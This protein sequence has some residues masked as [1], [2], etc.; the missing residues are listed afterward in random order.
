MSPQKNKVGTANVTTR[1]RHLEDVRG[2]IRRNMF[3]GRRLPM[4]VD[5]VEKD[6][7]GGRERNFLEPLMRFVRDDVRDLVASPKNDHGLSCQRYGASQ[8]CSCPKISICE[9]FGAVRFSTFSTVSVKGRHF[10][11]NFGCLLLL[12]QRT[13]ANP[14]RTSSTAA[15]R[16]RA[17]VHVIEG[18]Y[19]GMVGICPSWDATRSKAH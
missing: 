16:R 8:R 15:A 9:I 4:W 11:G 10:A 2:A 12:Q 17:S 5:T 7:L 6:F 19:Q 14:T 18:N 3:G 13:S 1:T